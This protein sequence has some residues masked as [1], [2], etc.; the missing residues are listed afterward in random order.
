MYTL[1]WVLWVHTFTWVE[2]R[3]EKRNYLWILPFLQNQIWH[4]HDLKSF[5]HV[6]ENMST[7]TQL[8]I[9]QNGISWWNVQY[10]H[11]YDSL[12][13][14]PFNSFLTYK[15]IIISLHKTMY[16]CK[17]KTQFKWRGRFVSTRLGARLESLFRAGVTAES[18]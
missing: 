18:F 12:I 2:R 14:N 7:Y 17:S 11:R 13:W 8:C 3:G 15:Y 9:F 10:H 4:L 16:L 5:F 6:Y 1:I